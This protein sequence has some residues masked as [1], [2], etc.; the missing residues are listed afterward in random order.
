MN[1]INKK[2]IL[3][4]IILVF[5]VLNISWFLITSIRYNKFVKVIPKNRAG[6]HAIRKEEL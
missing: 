2:R 6:V 5:T 3:I 4:F 1:K